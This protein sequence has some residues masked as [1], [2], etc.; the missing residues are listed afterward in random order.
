[1]QCTRDLRCKMM[2]EQYLEIYFIGTIERYKLQSLN[3]QCNEVLM[4]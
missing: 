2:V 4:F 1:M 3:I